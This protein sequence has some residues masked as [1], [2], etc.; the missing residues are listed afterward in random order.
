MENRKLFADLHAHT[1]ASDGTLSPKELIQ[2]F[3]RRG[4]AACAV[5]DH[6]TT[7]GLA[8]SAAAAA[9]LGIELVPGVEINTDWNGAEVHVLGYF[10][11]PE[12]AEFQGLLQRMRDGRA[13]R[14]EQMVRQLQAAGIPIEWERVLA[15]AAGGSI[16]RPH[17]GRALVDC[18]AAASLEEAFERYL[19]KGRPGYAPRPKLDPADAVRAIRQA[20]GAAVLAH[21]GLIGPSFAE[22]LPGLVEAGLQGLE[23]YHPSHDSGTSRNLL[24]IAQARGL[25]ATGGSDY[26]GPNWDRG[27]IEACRVPYAVVEKL[28]ETVTA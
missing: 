11:D 24:H 27:D 10:F 14:G 17:V 7:A 20:G 23:V 22:L 1:T 12:N 19:A 2:W 15:Y 4:L 9:E 8:E 18:G 6:D 13:R 25:I 28:R 26:H 21:P 16:G 5:S 3:K